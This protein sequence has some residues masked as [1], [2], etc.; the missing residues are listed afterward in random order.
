MLIEAMK[1]L[2]AKLVLTGAGP[3]ETEL[4]RQMVVANLQEKVFFVDE[5]SD[6]EVVIHLQQ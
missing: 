3:L 4:R 5:V 6:E 1:N 2:E